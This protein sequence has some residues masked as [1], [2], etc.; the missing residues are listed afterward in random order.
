MK[1]TPGFCRRPDNL[2]EGVRTQA[3]TLEE[4][5]SCF[6]GWDPRYADLESLAAIPFHISGAD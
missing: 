2:P 6:E 4:M 1:L 3:A 5:R